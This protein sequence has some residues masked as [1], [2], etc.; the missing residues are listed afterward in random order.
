MYTSQPMTGEAWIG[1]S[2]PRKEG[3]A[4]VTGHARYVDDLTLPGMIHG[5]TVRSPVP[6]GILRGIEYGPGIPWDDITVVTAAD[7]PGANVVALIADD[8][9]YLAAERINHPEEPVVLL[10]HADRVLLEEARRR[11][12]LHIDPLP[13]VFTIDASL[14]AD[15]V[16]WGADNILKSYVVG[17]GDVD[18]AW[19]RA[20]AIVEGEYET[21][22]QEQ[23]Y[24]EPNGMLAVVSAR[25][26]HG[27]GLDAVPLLHP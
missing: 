16:I 20:A 23:L 18:G 22:S 3:R 5:V 27:V 2:V 7:I 15:E 8:Q 4:K 17:Q 11:V 13:P 19:S 26:R 12:T 1:R 9:P 21:G 10:A 6:R 24:I 25:R 14:S